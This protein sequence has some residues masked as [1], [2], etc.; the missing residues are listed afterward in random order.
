[1]K[2]KTRRE[3]TKK[4]PK[5]GVKTKS[6]IV[7]LDHDDPDW[8][9]NMELAYMMSLTTQQRFKMMLARSRAMIKRLIEIGY[10]N[11]KEIV[12][13]P[14]NGRRQKKALKQCA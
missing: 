11:P 13:R 6:R 14:A 2:R 3:R 10:I 5:I 7:Y 12:M 8:E 1:M 9:L 4:I